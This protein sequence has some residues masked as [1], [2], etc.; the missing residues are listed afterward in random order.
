MFSALSLCNCTGFYA[1]I[2]VPFS[3]NPE[4]VLVWSQLQDS[5]SPLGPHETACNPS[6]SL[7]PPVPPPFTC[8]KRIL[9]PSNKLFAVIINNPQTFRFEMIITALLGEFKLLIKAHL[10]KQAVRHVPF[11]ACSKQQVNSNRKQIFW[12]W[13]SQWKICC[14]PACLLSKSQSLG[15]RSTATGACPIRSELS[16]RAC[17]LVLLYSSYHLYV[18]VVL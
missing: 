15:V 1:F 16:G 10:M 18:T 12:H 13:L 8:D 11:V 6:P 7:E 17:A 4:A 3:T 5:P 14:F 9:V 2:W